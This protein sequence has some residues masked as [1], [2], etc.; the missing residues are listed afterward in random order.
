[1]EVI[2]ETERLRATRFT[3]N[4]CAFILQLLN[5]PGWLQFIGDRKVR[6]EEDAKTYLLNGPLKSY[7]ENGFG[8][9][10]ITLK[11]T[12]KAIGMCGLIKRD[13]LQGVDIGF[14]FLPEFIGKGY[15]HEIAKG[16]L[17]Y[18]K[19]VLHLPAVLAIVMAENK[20]S[21]N[22]LEKIGLQF[23]ENIKLGDDAESLMLYSIDF[24]NG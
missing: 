14:A 4:D 18:A 23:R 20:R 13:T 17:L 21:V 10:L 22:L 1:M 7:D 11:S 16:T 15:A 19:E 24:N 9:A 3:T 2:L 12:N 8:L 5:T 6:T